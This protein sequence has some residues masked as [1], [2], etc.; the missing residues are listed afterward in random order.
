MAIEIAQLFVCFFYS[1][2]QGWKPI[3]LTVSCFE[4]RRVH[5]LFLE[6]HDDDLMLIFA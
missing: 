3:Q 2:K 4:T 1:V 5:P 6:L